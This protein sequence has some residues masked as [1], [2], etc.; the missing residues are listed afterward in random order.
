MN[1]KKLFLAIVAFF[2]LQQTQ[3]QF[4]FKPGL[5]GGF[6]FSTISE[7]HSNYKP[8]FYVGGFAELNIKKHYALQPEIT[9][10]RQ[11]SED[12][13]RNYTDANSG[14]ERTERRDLQ[15]DYLSFALI[16]KFTF[17]PGLQIQFGPALDV[18]V[19]DNLARRKTYNDLAFITGIA[20]KLS[21]NVTIEARVK[22][23]LLDVLDSDYYH[24]DRNDYYFFGDYNTNVNF[25]IGISYSFEGKK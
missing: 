23:G 6:T 1:S 19:A 4:S 2:A 9:Y 12:V 17:G 22:K 16:N 7:T 24:N 3:A 11:G 5:R 20:Y 10:T 25:Q 15:L 14:I 8:S 21:S 18:L 13:T